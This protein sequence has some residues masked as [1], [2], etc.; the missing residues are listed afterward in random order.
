VPEF[1]IVGC[2][3]APHSGWHPAWVD[4]VAVDAGP[5]TGNCEREGCDEQLAVAVGLDSVPSPRGPVDVV[6]V[7][8]SGEVHVTGQVDQPVGTLDQGGQQVWCECVHGE[9]AWMAFGAK[10]P[11]LDGQIRSPEVSTSFWKTILPGLSARLPRNPRGRFANSN[12]DSINCGV[13][14]RLTG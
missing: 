6:Q 9:C 11:S 2:A 12:I 13:P 8:V 14:I 5:S 10:R 4:G 1:D 3:R 7:G